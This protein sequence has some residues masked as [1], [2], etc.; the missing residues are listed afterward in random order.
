MIGDNGGVGGGH[1]DVN[2]F[3][4][5]GFDALTLSGNVAFNGPVSLALP[6]SISVASEG[7]LFANSTVNLSASYLSLGKPFL[8]PLAPGI[9]DTTLLNPP[10]YGSGVLNLTAGSQSVAGLIDVGDT[11]LQNIGVVTMKS[12]HGAIR[13]DGT[14][15]MAGALTMEAAEIYPPTDTAFTVVAN[16][17]D[18]NPGDPTYGQ[19]SSDAPSPGS[20]NGGSITILQSGTRMLPLSAGGSLSL[21]ADTITQ[22]GTLAAPFGVITMGSASGQNGPA[23]TSLVLAPGSLTTISE[24]L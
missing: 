17:Y 5:G 21:F 14:L 7:L 6:G 10:S 4:N 2:S 8:G 22:A 18:P 16:N 20:I 23:T 24:S 1:V 12:L 3:A 11:S 19:A 9:R 15:Q 13:G